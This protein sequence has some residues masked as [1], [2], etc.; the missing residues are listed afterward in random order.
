MNDTIII[1]DV[2][3]DSDF[4][5]SVYNKAI[6]QLKKFN[7]PILI[8]S[9]K[10]LPSDIISKVDYYFYDKTNLLFEGNYTNYFLL[11]DTFSDENIEFR[12]NEPYK[13]KHGLSVLSNLN[14]SYKL[15]HQLGFK[16]CVHFEA[17]FFV[18]DD[19]LNKITNTIDNFFINKKK[20]FFVLGKN[21][22][23]KAETCFY[24]WIVELDFWNKNF[25]EIFSEKD[26]ANFIYSKNNNYDFEI[27]ERIVYMCFEEHLKDKNIIET[28]NISDFEKQFSSNSE[29][30]LINNIKVCQKVTGKNG[31]RGICKIYDKGQQTDKLA[32]LTWNYNNEEKLTIRYNIQYYGYSANVIHENEKNQWRISILDYFDKSKFPLKLQITLNEYQTYEKI[33]ESFDQINYIFNVKK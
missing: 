32:I 15:A 16:Y 14:K 7:L 6:C 31:F 25:V 21:V 17:D 33:Y 27:A 20:A 12:G 30:N 9:N 13:Q 19:D 24:F 5:N 8:I 3:I 29:F 18:H 10:E 1:L 23:N 11:Y 22:F 4:K 2:Y 28:I 26:Y